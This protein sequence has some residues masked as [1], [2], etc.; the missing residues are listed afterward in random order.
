M[1]IM[2]APLILENP[3]VASG[4]FD[5]VSGLDGLNL[6][7]FSIFRD[8]TLSVASLLFT[9]SISIYNLLQTTVSIY[10]CVSRVII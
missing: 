1:P 4:E 7:H 6:I 5:R 3:L 9:E 10:K 2:R 8:A